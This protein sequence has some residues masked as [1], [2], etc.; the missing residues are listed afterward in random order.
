M[1]TPRATGRS[2]SNPIRAA[3][4]LVL[5]MLLAA[6][7]WSLSGQLMGWGMA[8]WLA[9][10]LSVMFDA[11]GLICATYARR[12]VERGTPAGLARLALLVFVAVAGLLN[13]NHGH[14]I[15]GAPAAAGFASLSAGVEL[16]FELHRR[17][18]RD[19]QRAARGLVAER[20]PHIPALGW[21]MYPG[22]SWQ[23][24]RRAVGVRL[25]LLDPVQTGHQITAPDTE[26]GPDKRRARTVRSAVRAAADTLP[27]ATA[28]DIVDHLSA[29]GIDTDTDTVHAVLGE[30]AD[31][32]PDRQDSS[33][34]RPPVRPVRP[35]APPGQTVA[36]T[37]RTALAS[38]ITD[39]DAVLSYVR[40]VHG[41]EVSADTVARTRRRI[42][43]PAS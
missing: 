28:E 36:D 43:R 3:W 39:K 13:W 40:K 12:A 38:G 37:V 26:T 34:P 14:D 23:T 6:A 33:S 11:A 21:I 35:I 9:W 25:D 2:L 17:D 41:Q 29:V 27:E 10:P 24:L 31:G 15:G 18:V 1:N 32:R 8:R 30:D 42:E 19:E 22:R 5:G 20:L 16:L 4:A 7:A